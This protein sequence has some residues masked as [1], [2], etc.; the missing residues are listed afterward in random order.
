MADAPFMQ[1]YVAD[2]LG[3]TRH[4]T[5]EQ[6]G[7]YLLLLMTMWRNGGTLPNDPRKLARI[8]GVNAR[9][10]HI[11]A[12]DVM[13][14]FD[15]V[16]DEITQN[17]LKREHEKAVSKRE[18]RIAS[19]SLGGK[20]KAL[21]NNELALANATA[22]GTANGYHSSEPESES[23]KKES[24]ND[25]SSPSATT[26]DDDEDDGFTPLADKVKPP[27]RRSRSGPTSADV[28]AA[29]DAWN[30]LAADLKLAEATVLNKTRIS[31]IKARLAESGA[32]GWAAALAKVR[33][34]RYLRGEARK[35]RTDLD[36]LLQESSFIKIMEGKYDDR[37]DPQ[38]RIDPRAGNGRGTLADAFR[39]GGTAGGDPRSHGQGRDDRGHAPAEVPA[40]PKP[41]GGG[42]GNRYTP[43]D[44][45]GPVVEFDVF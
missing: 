8:A 28:Q 12:D 7:A 38:P 27:P 31:R 15:V 10:W 43:S 17:R 5:T 39:S 45:D 21:K 13:A 11:L 30:A 6:H 18:K 22:N 24:S 44:G 42:A 25:D 4:L 29:F 16:G 2:Y 26:P 40:R 32:D 33:A 34:S 36:F 35:F 14:F 9:R 23:E 41:D 19:G 3:D 1:L 20:A 37:P